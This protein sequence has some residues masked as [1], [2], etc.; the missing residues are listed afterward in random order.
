MI[1]EHTELVEINCPFKKRT[2]R[3]N[4]IYDCNR[5]CIKV[6]PGSSG[7]AYCR[8]CKLT[9]EFEVDSQSNYKPRVVVQK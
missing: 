8:S 2:S 7:E 6:Y 5:V 3:G 9:F 1:R 4:V